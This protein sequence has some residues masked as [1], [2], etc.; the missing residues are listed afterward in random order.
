MPIHPAMTRILNITT[1]NTGGSLDVPCPEGTIQ[2][3]RVDPHG[4]I[5][6]ANG[7]QFS[8]QKNELAIMARFFGA[9]ALLLGEDIN[10]GWDA[11]E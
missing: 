9:A 3:R 1:T 2:C 8:I 10:A 11:P 7:Q 5:M 4:V 6:M